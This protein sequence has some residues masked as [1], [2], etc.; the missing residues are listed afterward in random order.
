MLI[1]KL[2]NTN[3]N[4][5][6]YSKAVN[7]KIINIVLGS[8]LIIKIIVFLVFTIKMGEKVSFTASVLDMLIANLF[9]IK[10]LFLIL[11]SQKKVHWINILLYIILSIVMS[12]KGNL[13]FL[14]LIYLI[15][16]IESIKPYK[17]IKLKYFVLLVVLMLAFGVIAPIIGY[18]RHG[19]EI[20]F[21]S[22]IDSVLGLFRRLGVFDNTMASYINFDS[23]QAH[24]YF[25]LLNMIIQYILGFLPNSLLPDLGIYG[26][27]TGSVFA[28]DI[29]GQDW[30]IRNA[31]E[32]SIFGTILLFGSGG[33]IQQFIVI[34][35]L[36][37]PF[38]LTY[39]L[40]NDIFIKKYA[41]FMFFVFII[42]GDIRTIALMLK[43][44][45]IYHLIYKLFIK[46]VNENSLHNRT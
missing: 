13:F 24:E 33:Y 19:S 16:N 1:F 20:I 10:L 18:L 31:Y 17:I 34:L 43:H 27:S 35:I 7:C 40:S 5:K 26:H 2:F 46:E 36:I 39:K 42:S 12:S 3:N 28:H 14:L 23:A 9:L 11:F 45:V 29:I 30:S 44:L 15:A 32:T 38:M 25:S 37:L 41:L 8:M 4:L 22:G 6:Y 21:F